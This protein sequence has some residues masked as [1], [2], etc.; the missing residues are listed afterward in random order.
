MTP[1]KS[2]VLTINGGSSSIKFA[3]F[4]TGRAIKEVLSGELENIGRA[5]TCFHFT[6]WITRQKNCFSID[7]SGHAGAGNYIIDWLENQYSLGSIMATGHRVVHGMNHK[8][9]E[10]I[11]DELLDELRGISTYDPEHLP[12][13]IQLIELFRRRYPSLP[14]IACFDTAF[15]AS[16]PSVAKMLPIP[17][18]YYV[19][20]IHRYGFHGISYSWLMEELGRSA[21]N[22]ATQGKIILAHLGS[23]ASLAAVKDGKSVDTSMGFTPSSGLVM[24][25][26]TG[27]LDPGVAGFLMRKEES[28]P[29]QFNHM[30]NYESGLLGISETSADMRELLKAQSTD[31]RAAEA[32]EMFCYQAKKWIGSFVAVLGGLDTLIFSGGIGEN[33]PEVRGR[34]CRDLQFL[35]II[36]DDKSNSLGEPVISTE[37]STVCVRVIKTNEELMMARMVTQILN[38]STR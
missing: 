19:M 23:G 15:H 20:G 27:D 17:R 28:G 10:K 34:I 26:R 5:N 30:I 33:A 7:A 1:I 31:K 22:E 38:K 18:K 16:M 8:E 9:P 32:V 3:L 12:E 4:D 14:Q 37:L 2:S 29:A 25:T 21:G 36:I 24:G 35:G 11:T 6:N 13:E